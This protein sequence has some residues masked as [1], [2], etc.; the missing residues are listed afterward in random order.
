MKKSLII[1]GVS[2]LLFSCNKNTTPTFTP[3][4]TT[5]TT[6]Y[7]GNIMMQQANN[8]IPAPNTPAAGVQVSVTIL[9]S[10]LYPTS[11]T[12]VGSQ[13]YSAT[14]NAMGNF[15]MSITTN[16][17]GA[18]GTITVSPITATFDQVAGTQATFNV[19][20]SPGT[21][22]FVSNVPWSANYMM[23]AGTIV[24][25]NGTGTATVMGKVQVMYLVTTNPV[26]PHGA[27]CNPTLF[28][29]A[30]QTVYLNFNEDPTTQQ[31]KTYNTTTA[32]DGTYTITVNT[33]STY[34]DI[35]KVYTLDFVHTMDTVLANGSFLFAGQPG[36]YTGQSPT[37]TT[38]SPLDPSVISNQN[39]PIYG[40]FNPN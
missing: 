35:G 22:V 30:N 40:T 29:L 34:A 38:V 10:A 21:H 23:N 39:N 20:A 32:A 6:T 14:T 18:L 13:T 26:N 17:N 7:S 37:N 16:G 8:G 2:I 36:Y 4:T 31:V 15:S 9:N 11:P 5:G 25:T 12:A 3:T 33:S 24:G 27:P 19:S 1:A 28:P